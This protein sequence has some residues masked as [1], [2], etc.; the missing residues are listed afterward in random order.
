MIERMCHRRHPHPQPFSPRKK[1]SGRR[2]LLKVHLSPRSVGEV[3][4]RFLRGGGG[5]LT[6]H[7]QAG[8]GDDRENVPPSTPSSPTL[9]PS[10]KT[11]REKGATQG[12]PLPAKRGRGR[13]AF[14]AWR[15]RVSNVAHTGR[16]WR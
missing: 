10:Q 15:G 13:H 16:L 9:L 12:S 6:L 14:F 5:F 2:E 3:D 7:I 11:L 4:T 8:F 1:R